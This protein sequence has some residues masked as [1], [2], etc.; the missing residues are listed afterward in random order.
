MRI[1]IVGSG[2]AG[3]TSLHLLRRTHDVTLFEA[4]DRLGGHTNTVRVDLPDG[5][6]DVDT[7]FI[8]H[9]A[10]NY[11]LLCRLFDELGVATQPSDMSFAVSDEQTGLEYRA[12]S[13]DTLLASRRNALRPE[14]WR[15]LVDIVAFHRRGRRFLLDPDPDLTLRQWLDQHRWSTAFEPLFL[16]PLV[17]AIWSADPD[18]V[19][20][21]PAAF[22]LQFLANHGLLRVRDVPQWRTVTGG[23]ST[24]VRRLVEHGGGRVHT[25]APVRAIRRY[26]D[27]VELDVAQ[28]GAL[29]F[30]HV[31]MALHSDQALRVLDDASPDEKDLLGTIDYQPNV[32]LLHTDQ[33][34]MPNAKRAWA[35]WNYHR[36]RDHSRMATLTY[37]MNRLQAL[38]TPTDLFVTLNREHEID[39]ATVLGRFHYE[40]PVFTTDAVQS[41]RQIERID[42]VNRTSFCGAYWGNGFHEDGVRSA[43]E[44]CARLG[45]PW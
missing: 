31:V 40:H 24:Y 9:N 2:I 27:R 22:L 30:D 26:D 19:D 42:G 17:A 43:V 13:L 3:L 7:G 39:P 25:N 15:L 33:R 37:H 1:A 28:F 23:S 8:V 34:V 38:D 6:V 36:P 18:T 14:W 16:V 45:V 10:R 11:P 4:D 29:E 12:T 5:P 21:Q 41:Q 44:A 20:A 32:A 35:S